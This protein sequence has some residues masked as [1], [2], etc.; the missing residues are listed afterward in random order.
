MIIDFSKMSESVLKNFK[1][2]EKEFRAKMFDTDGGKIMLSR[3]VKGASIGCHTHEN[4]C[5]IIYILSG[6]GKVLYDGAEERVSEGM[7]HFCPEGHSHSLINDGEGDLV[8]FAAV[9]NTEG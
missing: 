2:G 9:I 4:N 8:F 7:C 3:L 1:G 6:S 5:E